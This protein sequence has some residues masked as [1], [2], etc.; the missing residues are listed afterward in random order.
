MNSQPTT[1]EVPRIRLGIDLGTTRTVMAVCDAFGQAQVLPNAEGDWSTPSVVA[2]EDG[3]PIVG[4]EAVRYADV[5]PDSVIRFAKR[6]TGSKAPLLVRGGVPYTALLVQTVILKK[7][8]RDAKAATGGE[9]AAATI[10]VP[11]FFDERKRREVLRAGTLAGLP[12]LSILNEPTAA[13]IDYG[14]LD[15]G[16]APKTSKRNILVYDLGGGTFDV[17]LVSL[18]R[19]GIDVLAVDGNARLGGADWDQKIAEQLIMR[20]GKQTTLTAAQKEAAQRRLAPICEAAKHTLT[21]RKSAKVSAVIAGVNVQ[22]DVTRDEFQKWTAALLDRTRFL[23]KK[24]LGEAKVRAEDLEAVLLVGGSTRMPQVPEMLSRFG[25]KVRASHSPDQAVARGAAIFASEKLADTLLSEASRQDE[26][27]DSPE[28]VSGSRVPP[29]TPSTLNTGRAQRTQDGGVLVSRQ[30]QIRDVNSHDLGVIGI[31]LVTRR[32]LRQIMIPR[33][34]RLPAKLTKRFQTVH[35]N[36]TSVTIRVVEG[37]DRLGNGSSSVG[38]FAVVGLREGLPK[39]T[40]IDVTF[41]YNAF[42]VLEVTADIHGGS[43]MKVVVD[44]KAADD[45]DDDFDKM[46]EELLALDD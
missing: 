20:A 16:N 45:D 9:I 5:D 27:E 43:S 2:I 15:A 17:S 37:G 4:Q 34:T 6:S 22:M 41:G 14:F 26:P 33:N 35:D 28:N 12:S 44:R 25:A 32:P 8:A 19:D 46:I 42:G 38:S 13:A 40:P 21:T 1:A 18:H 39:G 10:T 30:F 29:S 23:I 31:E 36:Q 7:M 3:E 24:V 11:A